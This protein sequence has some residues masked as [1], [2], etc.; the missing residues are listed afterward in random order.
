MN[1]YTIYTPSHE[2]FYLDYF[3]KT[4]PDEFNVIATQIPQECVT[5]EFYSDGWNKT[6]YRKVELF[7]EACRK[8][9]GKMFF[10][11]D[12]DIQFFGNIKQTLIKELGDFDIACQD[13]LSQFSSG[14]FICRC[15]DRT[16]SLFTNMKKMYRLEDQATLN[17]QIGICKHKF[18]S[19]RFFTSGQV[20]TASHWTGQDFD[21]PD[22][23]LSH[24][25]NWVKGI[26]D[27]IKVL[28]IVRDKFN[29]AHK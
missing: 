2:V 20:I 3:L 13:D 23:I 24:H 28:D 11:S 5:G 16:L 1:L 9:M 18:L 21:I 4:L 10:F 25:S 14:Q 15:N 6:C 22:N 8:N 17:D 29:K 27:K 19:R 12:V 26:D 7:Y